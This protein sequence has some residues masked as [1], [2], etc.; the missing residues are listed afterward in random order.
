MMTNSSICTIDSKGVGANL[1][2]V[3]SKRRRSKVELNEVREEERLR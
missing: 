3:G 1:F 2:K